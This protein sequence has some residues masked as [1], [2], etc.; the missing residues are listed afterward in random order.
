MQKYIKL[1]INLKRDVL[2]YILLSVQAVIEH[3]NGHNYMY[4]GAI[5]CVLLLIYFK[6]LKMILVQLPALV[7]KIL[8]KNRKK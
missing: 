8:H 5:I 6:E 3:Y 7:D 2:A 4:Q 1:N